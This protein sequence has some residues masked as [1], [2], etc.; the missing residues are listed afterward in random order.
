MTQRH[1]TSNMMKG[2]AMIPETL[3]LLQEW[4]PGVPPEEWTDT[5]GAQNLLGKAPR[6]RG[7]DVLR[8]AF[9]R[10][11]AAPGLP[12]G[13]HVRTLMAAGFPDGVVRRPLYF[14]TALADDRLYDFVG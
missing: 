2:G 7:R 1:Y 5:V 8:R 14:P 10:R 6:A 4:H 12:S 3:A 11:V 13:E 9:C